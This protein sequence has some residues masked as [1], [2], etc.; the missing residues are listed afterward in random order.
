METTTSETAS[1]C[2]C[3]ESSMCEVQATVESVTMFSDRS[4]SSEQPLVLQHNTPDM[5]G[6]P[7][8][9]T[10]AIQHTWP[11]ARF[12]QDD[13][14]LGD[15]AW[16]THASPNEAT[17]VSETRHG[18]TTDAQ[19]CALQRSDRVSQKKRPS[20]SHS[21]SSRPQPSCLHCMLL[22]ALPNAQPRVHR[23]TP[24]HTSARRGCVRCVRE[25]IEEARGGALVHTPNALGETP[26]FIAA[27]MG[28]S[29]VVDVLLA[30]EPDGDEMASQSLDVDATHGPGVHAGDAT[31]SRWGN[32]S[33]FSDALYQASARGHHEPLL[34][35]P[36]R[37]HAAPDT[38]SVNDAHAAI[39]VDIAAAAPALVRWCERRPRASS[40]S[41]RLASV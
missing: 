12:A 41:C 24:L 18:R 5:N 31:A 15:A 40:F 29:A 17:T 21:S 11:A 2:E 3:T 39:T 9:S 13:F 4:T 8:L 28:H 25:S 34:P 14:V 16:E 38:A 22:S 23:D 6:S 32:T 26:M 7:L 33:S 37:P 19:V 20:A 10:H 27:A 36:P 1:E 30:A 35:C